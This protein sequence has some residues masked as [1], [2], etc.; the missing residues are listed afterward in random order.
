MQ[1]AGH[2]VL[3]AG[4]W[5]QGAGCGGRVLIVV[6]GCWL[7]WQRCWW[8]QYSSSSVVVVVVVPAWSARSKSSS[9]KKPLTRGPRAGTVSRAKCRSCLHPEE[10]RT[11]IISEIQMQLTE[12]THLG[13]SVIKG[14]ISSPPWKE[15]GREEEEKEGKGGRMS[16]NLNCDQTNTQQTQNGKQAS[17][18]STKHK[19]IL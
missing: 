17:H 11:H 13:E 14:S 2:R 4:C 6:A 9:P 12:C 1:G 3:V 5:L 18:A 19:H 10:L 8:W 15:K 7:W 16:K